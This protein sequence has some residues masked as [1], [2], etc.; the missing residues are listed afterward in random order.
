MDFAI[1]V[2][3]GLAAILFLRMASLKASWIVNMKMEG[4]EISWQYFVPLCVWFL[5]SVAIAFGTVLYL[6]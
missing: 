1:G 5:L 4:L 6:I 2:I 3:G